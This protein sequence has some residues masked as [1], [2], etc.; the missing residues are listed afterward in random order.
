MDGHAAFVGGVEAFPE[1]LELEVARRALRPVPA[2]CSAL[3]E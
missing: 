2:F 1:V 3:S